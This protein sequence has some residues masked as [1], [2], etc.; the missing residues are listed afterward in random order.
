MKGVNKIVRDAKKYMYKGD[1]KKLKKIR[2]DALRRERLISSMHGEQF[3]VHKINNVFMGMIKEESDV[4]AFP[5]M[6]NSG[7]RIVHTIAK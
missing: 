6:S 2:M 1:K 4:H 5:P 7:R 3:N